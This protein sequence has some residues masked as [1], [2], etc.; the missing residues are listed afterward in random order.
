MTHSRNISPIMLIAGFVCI[1]AVLVSNSLPVQ[2]RNHVAAAEAQQ[3]RHLRKLTSQYLQ[4]HY[5]PV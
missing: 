3:L 2:G 5:L 1:C 4:Q